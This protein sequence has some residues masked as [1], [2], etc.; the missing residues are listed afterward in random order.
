M[1][2]EADMSDKMLSMV[3]NMEFLLG[4]GLERNQQ[5]PPKFVEQGTLRLKHGIEY[6]GKDD[7]E[8]EF[9]L[10]TQFEKE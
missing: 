10:W 7:S 3:R 4:M 5:G 2:Y 9:D 1:I 6:D 8:E